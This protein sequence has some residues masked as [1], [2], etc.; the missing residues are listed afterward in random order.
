[1][2]RDIE[3]CRSPPVFA[4]SS[5]DGQSRKSATTLGVPRTVLEVFARAAPDGLTFQATAV[6]TAA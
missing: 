4:L 3:A 1:M 5:Y 6:K 2:P